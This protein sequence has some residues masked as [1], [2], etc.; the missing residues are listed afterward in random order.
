M[1]GAGIPSRLTVSARNGGLGLSLYP[2]AI[3]IPN[4]SPACHHRTRSA[5]SPPGSRCSRARFAASGVDRIAPA[6]RRLGK[7][8]GD[9]DIPPPIRRDLPGNLAFAEAPRD[10]RVQVEGT[11]TGRK[12]MTAKL[13]STLRSTEARKYLH[14][15][16]V[17]Y[18]APVPE[19]I[20]PKPPALSKSFRLIFVVTAYRSADG[21]RDPH[22]AIGLMWRCDEEAGYSS[23]NGDFGGF[24]QNE[25]P[26]TRAGVSQVEM[27]AGIG[28]EPMTFRL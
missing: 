13:S 14:D 16:E 15:T 11:R 2:E 8:V 5:P 21:A 26:G 7:Q 1:I 19:I 18:R 12:M 6:W 23:A 9:R 4:V 10:C 28:F 17:R 22:G 20:R 25:N 27:V 24:P 3:N